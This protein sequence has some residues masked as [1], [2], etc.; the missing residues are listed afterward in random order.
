VFFCTDR[1]GA[2]GRPGSITTIA[3]RGHPVEVSSGS[4]VERLPNIPTQ[5]G[6]AA[7]AF[8]T[9]I[10]PPDD[11]DAAVAIMLDGIH[12]L[13]RWFPNAPLVADYT[14]GTKTMTAALVMAAIESDAVEPQLVTGARADLVKVY[15]G[16][17]AGV[18]VG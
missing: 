5:A 18:A 7:D 4:E 17:Q 2:T 16:S 6:L 10:V 13:R 8:D 1:A 11:L 15:D 12:D 3:G 14:G 9:R